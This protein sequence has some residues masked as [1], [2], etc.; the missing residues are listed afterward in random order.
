MSAMQL[1]RLQQ[2][3]SSATAA[4]P[5]V[6]A[7]G[8]RGSTSGKKEPY[9]PKLVLIESPSHSQSCANFG[10]FRFLDL[11]GVTRGSQTLGLGEKIDVRFVDLTFIE[12]SKDFF[13]TTVWPVPGAP[14]GL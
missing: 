14:N 10:T 12:N 5:L 4:T 2:L 13:A 6:G 3:Q 1:Q 11:N 7:K 9:A 8:D